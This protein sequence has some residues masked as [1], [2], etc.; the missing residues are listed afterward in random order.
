L[1]FSGV[2][3]G[4]KDLCVLRY[5]CPDE[6]QTDLDKQNCGVLLKE[7]GGKLLEIGALISAFG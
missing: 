7:R 5:D 4:G 2:N 1:W 3:K 6:N